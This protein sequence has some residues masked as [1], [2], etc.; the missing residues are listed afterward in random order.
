MGRRKRRTKRRENK[1]K[2][3][4]CDWP[5]AAHPDLC[6]EADDWLGRVLGGGSV[7]LHA[8]NSAL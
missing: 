8:V 6:E 7:K 5:T 2:T 1:C 4:V 3:D